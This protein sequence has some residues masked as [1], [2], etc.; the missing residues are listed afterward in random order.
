MTSA[1]VLTT[2]RYSNEERSRLRISFS[3]EVRLRN[4]A[5]IGPLTNGAEQA[6]SYYRYLSQHRARRKLKSIVSAVV[7]GGH[8]EVGLNSLSAI[9]SRDSYV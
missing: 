7:G 6:F 8:D 9:K 5:Q 4:V 2:A 1:A 3:S